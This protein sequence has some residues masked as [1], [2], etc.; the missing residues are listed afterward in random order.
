MAEGGGWNPDSDHRVSEKYLN[1]LPAVRWIYNYTL[2]CSIYIENGEFKFIGDNNKYI[3]EE[4][5]TKIPLE[6]FGE[7]KLALDIDYFYK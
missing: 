6:L 7:N 5:D 2:L 4:A 3:Y 1:Y